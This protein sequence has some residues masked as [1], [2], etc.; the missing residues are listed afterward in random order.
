MIS[1]FFFALAQ[2]THNWHATPDF[3]NG[4]YELI[5]GWFIAQDVRKLIEHKTIKGVYWPG[6]T[7]FLSWGV[8]NLYYYPSYDQWWSFTGGLAICSANIVWVALACYYTWR[9]SNDTR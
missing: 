8:W 9:S 3:F 7:F 4:L 6:R 2:A 1:D 5:G